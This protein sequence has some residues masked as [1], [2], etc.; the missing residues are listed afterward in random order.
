MGVTTLAQGGPGQ[1]DI[2]Q[3]LIWVGALIVA[4]VIGTIVLLVI[5]RKLGQQ[6]AEDPG[7]FTTME[8]MRAMVDR[9]EMTREE[10]EK[11]REAMIAKIRQSKD[12]PQ[13]A[14]KQSGGNQSR[15]G[16]GSTPAR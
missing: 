8:D 12:A 11:V 3:F 5:R 4:V 10:Y 7:G 9:G 1:G 2:G 13:A 6:T 16:T 15:G 14:K